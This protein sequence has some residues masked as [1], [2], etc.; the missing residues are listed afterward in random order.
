MIS[1]RQL[2]AM[3][4]EG[5]SLHVE[6][7]QRFSSHEKIAKEIIAFANTRGG[8]IFLGVDDNKSIYGVESE[9]SDIDLI[10]Q[11]AEKFCEPP[12]GFDCKFISIDG[13][14]VLVIHV[15]ESNLKPHRIQDYKTNLDL[16][17]SSVYIRINDKS[18]PASKEMIKLLQSRMAG[19]TLKQYEIGNNEK[20]V[21]NYL[22]LNE[23]ITVKE[24]SKLAN[25]SERR[26]SRTLIKLVRADLL[27][28]H[29]KDNGESYF[30]SVG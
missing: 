29:T 17:E 27:L 22:E 30:T 13:K 14:D 24:L 9:K 26:A 11:T 8:F 6:F 28:I 10:K 2:I 15:P 12:V 7:K 16:N 5:E 18:V 25:I 21:F 19:N 20:I 4:D 23:K 1:N 3:I